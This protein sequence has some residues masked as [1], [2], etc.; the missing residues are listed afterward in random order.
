M[1]GP[2]SFRPAE[3]RFETGRSVTSHQSHRPIRECDQRGATRRRGSGRCIRGAS[4]SPGHSWKAP[5]RA[6]IQL[7][8]ALG[9]LLAEH[10]FS[11]TLP[12]GRFCCDPGQWDQA[13][14]RACGGDRQWD[15][16]VHPE[17]KQSDWV[18]PIADT[19]DR[20]FDFDY[21][22]RGYV[23]WPRMLVGASSKTTARRR[24]TAGA[25]HQ[26]L[27]DGTIGDPRVILS[28]KSASRYYAIVSDDAGASGRHVWD[29]TTPAAPTSGSTR[30]GMTYAIISS[31]KDDARGRIAIITALKT[32]EIYDVGD[33]VA[34]G[35]AV[36]SFTGGGTKKFKDVTVDEDGNFWTIEATSAP[37][38]N[39]LVKLE[40]SGSG[41][42]KRTFDVLGV[43]T[44]GT[45]AGE[46]NNT[47]EYGDHHLGIVG[48]TT[49][50]SLDAGSSKLWEASP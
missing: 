32:L 25:L 43:F 17:G 5:P 2:D 31:A 12:A 11:S 19:Q 3:C 44:P 39:K 23:Y 4:A 46:T 38:N 41:Y 37:E 15:A 48:K 6:Y 28:L 8:S 36:A 1:W 45:I 26:T 13:R 24:R 50:N 16:L 18:T 49:G 42:T 47:I 10:V 29:V 33:L 20:L 30:L 40:R 14:G 7:G 35:S 27:T 34:G 22:D 9:V 21:D